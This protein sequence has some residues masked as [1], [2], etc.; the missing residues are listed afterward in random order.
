MK[1][2]LKNSVYKIYFNH[3]SWFEAIFSPRN[4]SE[5]TNIT[6]NELKWCFNMKCKNGQNVH[7]LKKLFFSKIN[8]WRR[9]RGYNPEQYFWWFFFNSCFTLFSMLYNFSADLINPFS[10]YPN[11][12][13]YLNNCVQKCWIYYYCNRGQKYVYVNVEV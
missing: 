5:C 6:L 13:I 2:K 4:V 12:Y 11:K 1:K 7:V 8:N 10:N 9:H 3:S